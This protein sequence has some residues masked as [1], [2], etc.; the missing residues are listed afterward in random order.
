MTLIKTILSA[1]SIKL[2]LQ[3]STGNTSYEAY[4]DQYG[5]DE[6]ANLVEQAHLGASAKKYESGFIL[7]D[8]ESENAI[9]A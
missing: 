2:G 7:R 1:K 3:N 8:A 9:Y 6:S 5:N 4:S